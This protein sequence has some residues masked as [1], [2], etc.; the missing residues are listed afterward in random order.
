MPHG[1]KPYAV[2][3]LLIPWT[4][5]AALAFCKYIQ[6]TIRA[7]FVR[8]TKA[9]SWDVE[10]KNDKDGI[11]QRSTIVRALK[12]FFTSST[13]RQN[14]SLERKGDGKR[15]ASMHSPISHSFH[16]ELF[17]RYRCSL[18][19]HISIPLYVSCGKSAR[20]KL[21]NDGVAEIE[22][23]IRKKRGV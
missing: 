20:A 15:L 10:K 12:D 19:L 13:K 4:P 22:T 8:T 9:D 21:G 7:R 2:L 5:R 1:K 3:A 14:T 17:T 23:L 18:E 6:T 11:R 16:A